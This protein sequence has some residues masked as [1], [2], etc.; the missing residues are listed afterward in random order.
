MKSHE[1]AFIG[2]FLVIE[3]FKEFNVDNSVN[4]LWIS[5]LDTLKQGLFIDKE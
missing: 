2:L 3:H 1:L 5:T 4:K